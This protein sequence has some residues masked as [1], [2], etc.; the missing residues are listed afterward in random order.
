MFSSVIKK[1]WIKIKYFIYALALFGVVVIGYFW[2]NLNFEFATIEPKSMM[3]YRF[4]HLEQKP[5]FEFLYFFLLIGVMVSL[6]QFIPERVRNRIKIITHLPISLKKALIIHLGVGLFFIVIVCSILSVFIISIILFYYPVEILGVVVKDLFFFFLATLIV[7]F[8][9]SAAIIDKSPLVGGIK[10]FISILAIFTFFKLRFELLDLGFLFVIVVLFFVVLD[11]FYSIKE[12]RLSHL[13]FKI[14]AFLSLLFVLFST[15]NLYQNKY[16]T[17]FTKYYIFYSPTLGEFV[18]QKNFGDHR[19]EYASQSGTKFDQKGYESTLPF[20]YWRDLEIQGLLPLDIDGMIYDK[21]TIQESRLS[22]GYE[23]KYLIKKE[24]ELYPLINPQTTLGMIRFP[25]EAI[26]FSDT[27]VRIYDS[28]HDHEEECKEEDLNEELQ[29][30]LRAYNVSLP[31]KQIYG[32]A[33][34]MKPYDL[35]YFIIDKNDRLFNLHRADYTLHLKELP[36]SPYMKIAHI[37]ISEN[38]QKLLA[39]Y[40]IDEKNNFYIIDYETL[41]F[42]SVDLEGFDY[43]TMRL[44]LYSDPK[45]YLI[46]YDDGVSY[47]ARVYDKEFNFIDGI[48]VK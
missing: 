45:Y 9:I 46:R 26:V 10:F 38:R 48:V 40:A 39:G 1:E 2:Y 6:T 44:Q 3:W 8:G 4:A 17:S 37:E 42:K 34:N 31:I 35:G 47:H 16:S 33:T 18:Y 20:V 5:Y 25:S 30:L 43:K 32:K 19:F 11:S 23:P 12:Q 24:L 21:K 14:F 13:T 27:K 22:F 28:E 36:S 15:L 41:E 7:Y 29:T